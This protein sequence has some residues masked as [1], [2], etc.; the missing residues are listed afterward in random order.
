MA[1]NY[2]CFPYIWLM[3]IG[4]CNQALDFQGNTKT[5][6]ERHAHNLSFINDTNDLECY[7]SNDG[8]CQIH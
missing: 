2:R 8:E 3:K 1:S 6:S 5:V 4:R 7:I